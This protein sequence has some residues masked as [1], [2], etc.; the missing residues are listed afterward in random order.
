MARRNLW[1]ALAF[2]LASCVTPPP[3]FA[4][5]SYTKMPWAK[6]SFDEVRAD[7]RYKSLRTDR[8]THQTYIH[9]TGFKACMEK[10]GY[11]YNGPSGVHAGT[12]SLWSGDM[13]APDAS[14][15]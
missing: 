14:R 8:R 9:N 10:Y 1:I 11:R 7:C 3:V 15:R 6:K 12:E 2:A 13:T 5:Q 4:P